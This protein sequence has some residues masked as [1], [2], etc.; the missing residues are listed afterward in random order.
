MLPP[1]FCHKK[2]P[3]SSHIYETKKGFIT[4]FAVFLSETSGAVWKPAF[5]AQGYGK[6]AQKT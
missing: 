2:N 3:L 4:L 6:E 1:F 5:P